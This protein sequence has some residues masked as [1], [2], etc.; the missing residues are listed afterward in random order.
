MR[1]AYKYINGRADG[2]KP[3]EGHRRRWENN[4]KMGFTEIGRGLNMSGSE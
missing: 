3:P 2:K 4:I 1:N